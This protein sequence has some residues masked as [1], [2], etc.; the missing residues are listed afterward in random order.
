[1]CF[2]GGQRLDWQRE[3]DSHIIYTACASGLPLAYGALKLPTV[4]QFEFQLRQISFR[5]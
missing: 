4:S 3:I 5:D 2:D 1:M